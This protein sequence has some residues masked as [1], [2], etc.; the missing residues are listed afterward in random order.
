M[1]RLY[2][3]HTVEKDAQRL[4][5]EAGCFTATES[6]EREKFYCLA[7]FPYPSGQLHMG[8]VRCY[9][10]GDV[11]NR[12]QRLKGFNVMQPMGWDAFGLPAENA[13]IKHGIPPA[14][15]TRD[16]IEY[17]KGQMKSL[18]FG[19]DWSR[20][21]ATCDPTYYHWEQWF[22]TK[23]Y[24]KGLVYRKNAV[25]NWD[26]VEQ[27]V[28]ANEQVEDG[29]GWRSGA[30]VERREMT[31]WFLKITDYAEELLEELDNLPGWPDSVKTMQRN[32]IGR[33]EG[34][35]IDFPVVGENDVLSVYTTRPDT[36]LGATYVA[37]AAA[38]PL[39]RRAADSDETV[40]AFVDECGKATTAEADLATMDKAGVVTN[41]TVEHPLTG[42]RLP[43]WVAN[44]V[45]MEYGS[46][47]VMAVPGHDQ[48]DW[49][50]AARYG[51]PIQQVIEPLDGEDAE[52][53]DLAK[54]AYVPYGRLVN[55]GEFDGMTSEE[56]FEA[57]ADTLEAKGRGRRQ[58]HFRLRDW[59][60]SRQR[61]WGCP[62]PMIHCD[63]CGVVPV[64]DE[65][66]PVV[67][68]TDVAFE[69]VRS[70]LTTMESF[71]RT[72]CP[73]CG[74]EARRETDTFDTFM[75]SSWYYA[76]FASPD[77][78][79]PVV[80]DRANYWTPVDH[81]VGGIEHAILHLLYARFYHK[82]MRDAGLVNSDE[83]FTRLL[84][85]GMVL[86]DG[87]K[88]SKSAGDAGDP[89]HLLNK[90]GADAVRTAMMFA[91]PP[92][93][94]F[95]W[96]EAGVEGQGRFLKRLWTLVHERLDGEPLA[97][98]DPAHLGVE[99]RDV[100]RK[101]HETLLRADDDYGRRLQF[102]TVVSAVHELV[103]ALTRMDVESDQDRAVVR[104]ALKI[105]LAVLSPIAP[106]VTQ[107][108]WQA[109][110]ETTL[111]VETGWPAVDESALMQDTFE[112]VVQVNGKVR[113]HVELAADAD[114]SAARTAALANDNVARFVADKT[115]RKVILVP[116]KLL[117]IVVG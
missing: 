117:N 64:P 88:M 110:G 25:V 42:E 13:A 89:Q 78:N 74:G 46:G 52:P 71:Y 97:E 66:L 70:P 55:S 7:M 90:Y 11:I 10:L 61:Y 35:E 99:A 100:R 84:M 3:P 24:E 62:I 12:Y 27:T 48:R 21:F 67:L 109:M 111:L 33:S 73:Q 51:I 95:E 72:T 23:L 54:A 32:W 6:S 98:L 114:E 14:I 44:F 22:F 108:L 8:H 31:Q 105:T 65:E 68:P 80:D 39:A 59:G 81:Y 94:S 112:L 106:H 53:C 4:W 102:N 57:I 2:N 101:A 38:H 15:W 40:A 92:D 115:V 103:N 41:F 79:R 56:A 5:E 63:A 34:V 28:L 83:P 47:A 86:K 20:E 37:V 82:L 69:G 93:Q 17:M 50:F 116:G 36:L 19:I 107:A 87:R 9:T 77:A 1:S 91:A 43:V 60:V 104:E 58:T 45:L 75:E 26:P 113:G 76:R 30:L 49:E 96:S 16:N 85:L 29:R 18:G